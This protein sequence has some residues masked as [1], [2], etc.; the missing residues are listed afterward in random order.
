MSST[1]QATPSN[2]NIQSIID[3]AL[4]NYAKITGIDLSESP[5]APMLEQ[6]NSPEAILVLLQERQKSF[7]TY[8]D[9]NRR[10][11]SSLSPAVTIIHA[12]SGILGEAASL[13]STTYHPANLLIWPRQISFS[14]AKAVFTSIDVLL[15]VRLLNTF[16]S[17]VLCNLRLCQA[18]SGVTSSYDALLEQFERL[19]NFLQRLE[20]Y[21]KI[22][23][24][25]MMTDIIV[26]I[27]VEVLSV[28]ALATKQV[29][30]GRLSRFTIT[31]IAHVSLYDRIVCQKAVREERG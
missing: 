13:V 8:R 12:F 21:M 7:I 31:F 9:R 22:P 6:S 23:P 5:F 11:I 10:L 27:M 3:A 16:F 17:Q 14:P 4:A 30:Q 19:G 1:G 26:R 24:T 20:I 25:T 2:S 18:A 29:K 28:L 15:T